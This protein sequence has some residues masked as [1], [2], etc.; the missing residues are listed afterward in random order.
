MRNLDIGDK[1]E[2]IGRIRKV[3]AI[4]PPLIMQCVISLGNDIKAG[5]RAHIDGLTLWLAEN[6]RINNH[7]QHDRIAQRCAMVV[8]DEHTVGAIVFALHIGD[9]EDR[10][11]RPGDVRLIESPLII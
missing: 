3:G 8:R 9:D 1:Q 11:R 2:T 7:A 4:V 6:D 10:A 5:S